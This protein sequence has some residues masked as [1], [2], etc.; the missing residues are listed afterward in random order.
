M[1]WVWT[2]KREGAVISVRIGNILIATIILAK[3][4]EVGWRCSLQV[5]D[6]NGNGIHERFATVSEALKRIHHYLNTP[7]SE[8]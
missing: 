5:V 8:E 7:P 6:G 4:E 2:S 1:A 3:E